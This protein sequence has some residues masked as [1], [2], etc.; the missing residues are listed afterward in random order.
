MC[1]VSSEIF[2]EIDSS[3]NLV[4]AKDAV[5]TTT[6]LLLSENIDQVSIHVKWH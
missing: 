2:L 5:Y 6:C 3:I 4:L 1:V